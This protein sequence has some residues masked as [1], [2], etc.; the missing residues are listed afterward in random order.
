MSKSIKTFLQFCWSIKLTFT[1]EDWIC[2]SGVAIL[3]SPPTRLLTP[4]DFFF[5]TSRNRWKV[6]IVLSIT[7]IRSGARTTNSSAIVL[8]TEP[9][10]HRPDLSTHRRF[11]A[12]FLCKLMYYNVKHTALLQKIASHAF[13][14]DVVNILLMQENC[15]PWA[16][17][18][19]ILGTWSMGKDLLIRA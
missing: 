13:V 10:I 5:S 19:C 16:Y 11:F 9:R 2:S 4:P 8:L 18:P 15:C 7:L 12:G 6:E 3:F 14:M 1:R 17:I